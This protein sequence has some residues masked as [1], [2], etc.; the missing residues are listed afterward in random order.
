M[1][2]HDVLFLFTLPLHYLLPL[3][4]PLPSSS[5]SEGRWDRATLRV[6]GGASLRMEVAVEMVVIIAVDVS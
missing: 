2:R 3:S 5:I 1:P 6:D 4:F